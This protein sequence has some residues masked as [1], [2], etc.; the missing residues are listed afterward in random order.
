MKESDESKIFETDFVE[1]MG[2]RSN[3]LVR[4]LPAYNNQHRLFHLFT[5]HI[6]SFSGSVYSGAGSSL[7]E[8]D[9]GR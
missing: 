4:K 1:S 6:V 2:S 5:F 3:L 9:K 7:Y 8:V